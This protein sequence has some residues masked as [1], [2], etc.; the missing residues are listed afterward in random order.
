[1]EAMIRSAFANDASNSVS[2]P[3]ITCNIA[4]SKTMSFSR[5]ERTYAGAA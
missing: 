4:T 1:M 3:G 5:Y 2:R